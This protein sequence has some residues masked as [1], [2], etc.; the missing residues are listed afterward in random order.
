MHDFNSLHVSKCVFLKY[1]LKVLP[2]KP[3]CVFLEGA[4][5]DARVHDGRGFTVRRRGGKLI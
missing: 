2:N 1:I 5:M 4:P 3:V